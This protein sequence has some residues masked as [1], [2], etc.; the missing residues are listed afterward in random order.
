MTELADLPVLD[1]H[2][3]I[4]AGCARLRLAVDAERI[5]GEVAAL[6]DAMWGSRGG[7]GGVHNLAEAIWLRGHAPAERRWPIEERHPFQLLPT[8][9]E[10]VMGTIPAPPMRCLLARLAAGSMVPAHAD[11][12][13]YFARTL[14]LHVP[15]ITN[16]GVKMF[17]D[18]RVYAMRPG[19]VW[20]LDNS[21]IHGV[22]NDDPGLARTHMIVDYLSSPGLLELLAAADRALGIEDAA[23]TRRFEEAYQPEAAPAGSGQ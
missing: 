21:G 16:P 19:E 11:S 15:I 17:A 2:R 22:I 3:I 10:L 20:A 9:R 5:R 18:G 13:E 23:V 14:R 12:G 8:L 7:R 1:K 4:G 6:P